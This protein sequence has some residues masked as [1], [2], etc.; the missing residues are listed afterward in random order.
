MDRRK[1]Q[2]MGVKD[3]KGVVTPGVPDRSDEVEQ[4]EQKGE[5]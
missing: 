1:R 4:V 3:G 5:G 2:Q